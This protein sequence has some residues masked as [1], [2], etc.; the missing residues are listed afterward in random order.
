[1]EI[2]DG[3][4]NT[5]LIRFMAGRDGKVYK[6]D[7]IRQELWNAYILLNHSKSLP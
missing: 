2:T 4:T 5:I 3:V 7:S 1:M 6:G